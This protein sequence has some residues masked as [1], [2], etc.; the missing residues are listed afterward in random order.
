MKLPWLVLSLAL[1][2]ILV[3]AGSAFA[4]GVTTAA[5]H[6]PGIDLSEEGETEEEC[7]ESSGEDEGAVEDEEECEGEAEES[8]GDS[9]SAEDCLLRTANARVV[10]VPA[11]NTVRLTLGYTTFESARA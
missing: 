10:A 3:A 5:I 1:L 2:T 4:D 9:F 8:G 6:S 7:V 11:Q